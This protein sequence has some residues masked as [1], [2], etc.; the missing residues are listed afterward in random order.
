MPGP[1]AW[2]GARTPR[3]AAV[4]AALI[5]LGGAGV[6]AALETDQFYAWG[7]YLEDATE[8]LNARVNLELERLVAELNRDGEHVACQ[9][10]RSRFFNRHRMLFFDGIETWS[11]NSPLVSRSPSGPDEMREFKQKTIYSTMTLLDTGTWMPSSPTVEVDGVRL[12]TDKLTHLLGT[13]WYYHRWYRRARARGAS[14][15][16]AELVALRRGVRAENT[17][18]G[19][20][21]SGVF[22]LA[23]LEANHQGMWFYERLCAGD[24]PTIVH[25]EGEWRLRRPFDMRDYVTPEWDESYQPNIY[26]R[27]KWAK[28]KLLLMGYCRM[29]EHPQVRARREAYAERDQVTVTEELIDEMV[30]AG[31]LPDPSGYTIENVCREEA[32]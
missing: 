21:V 24:D 6:A 27:R 26:S 28:V 12:G 22:S 20:L 2:A 5:G 18:L 23:D 30:A 25:E 14:P 13:A 15:G 1:A 8:V 9:N 4:A 19:K 11:M 16:E 31:K 32:G 3:L 17:I 7:R 10:V 29:L